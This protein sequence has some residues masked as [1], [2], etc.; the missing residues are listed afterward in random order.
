[1]ADRPGRPLT[2]AAD[3]AVAVAL[4]VVA[5]A[6]WVVTAKRM[7]GVDMGPGTDLGALGWF[8]GVWA[9]VMAAVVPPAL[10]R[11]AT[12][13]ER[14]D[15]VAD[16]CGPAHLARTAAFVLGYLAAWVG[17]GLVAYGVI[18]GIRALDPGF[19][20]WNQAG[21][22]IAGGVIVGAAAYELT[23]AKT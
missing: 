20:A 6:C 12:A 13:F 3:A 16:Q 19:L 15:R 5:G 18:K 22:Y 8:A 4:L 14:R 17:A 11:M 1:A 7:Q 23:P 21:R 9:T 10:V 2:G